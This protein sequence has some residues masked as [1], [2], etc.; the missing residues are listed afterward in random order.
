MCVYA[1][2]E[3]GTAMTFAQALQRLMDS[4]GLTAQELVEKTGINA[5]YF[6]RLLNGKIKDPTWEKACAI[7]D[8]FGISV[9]EF[10]RIQESE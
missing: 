10:K 3:I 7:I 9:D 5:P 2:S 4:R 6:S 1:D 8:A